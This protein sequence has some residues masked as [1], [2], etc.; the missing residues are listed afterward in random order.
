V[1]E[2]FSASVLGGLT[3]RK[4]FGPA[5]GEV[6]EALRRWT[7][8]RLRNVGR[9]AENAESKLADPDEPGAV[10]PRVAMYVL[11][12]GC[13]SDD[14]IVTDY[15]GGVLAASKVADGTDD[16]GTTWAALIARLPK[17]HLRT[18]YILYRTLRDALMGQEIN[19]GSE[20]DAKSRAKMYLPFEVWAN[21]MDLEGLRQDAWNLFDET[22]WS[23]HSENLIG[24]EIKFGG[25]SH[26]SI[27]NAEPGLIWYPSVHGVRLFLWAHGRRNHHPNQV[28]DPDLQLRFGTDIDIAPGARDTVTIRRE[29][30]EAKRLAETVEIEEL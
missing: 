30:A 24:N 19:L 4:L 17:A 20:D 8:Y 27:P 11:E 2:P 10:N 6:G 26:L 23:L 9:I 14:E 16:A 25:G 12:Q 29:A 1:V 7:E 5:A 18:H 15:L 3:L 21:A 13:W 22:I 28:L